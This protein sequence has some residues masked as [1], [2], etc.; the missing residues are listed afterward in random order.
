MLDDDSDEM[1]SVDDTIE[2]YEDVSEKSEDK[3]EVEEEEVEEVSV[4]CEVFEE[5]LK[6]LLVPLGVNAVSEDVCFVSFNN[7]T[8]AETAAVYITASKIDTINTVLC[9]KHLF[10]G[11][12]IPHLKFFYFIL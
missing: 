5:L 12:V 11:N 9:L 10:S 8:H 2:S 1:F 7:I 4:L 6:L 3:V